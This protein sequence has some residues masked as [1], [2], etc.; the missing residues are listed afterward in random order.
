M[1]PAEFK[2]AKERKEEGRKEGGQEG[3]S[4]KIFT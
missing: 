4:F 3:R 2:Y 1:I